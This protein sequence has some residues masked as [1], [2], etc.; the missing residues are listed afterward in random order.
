MWLSYNEVIIIGEK[1][2]N[3]AAEGE[4]GGPR[5]PRTLMNVR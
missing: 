4:G 5:Q 1:A 2:N 3:P